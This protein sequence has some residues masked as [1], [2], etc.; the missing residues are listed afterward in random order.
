MRRWQLQEAKNK[1]SEVTR[2][3]VSEGPQ[4]VT[5]RGKD[6]VVVISAKDYRKVTG[7]ESSL[8]DFLRRSPLADVDI[9]IER[10][11]AGGREVEM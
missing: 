5:K 4:L 6:N 11:M 10:D 3:A 8:V 2:L 1:F 7:R 9:P